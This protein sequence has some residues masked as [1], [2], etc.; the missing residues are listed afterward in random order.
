MKKISKIIFIFASPFAWF[1]LSYF[2]LRFDCPE[3]M[4]CPTGGYCPPVGKVSMMQIMG[5]VPSECQPLFNWPAVIFGLFILLGYTLIILK[6]A[7]KKPQTTGE[8][9][10]DALNRGVRESLERDKAI[11]KP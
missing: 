5:Q 8:M 11:N 6:W 4:T 10:V 7:L 3:Q 2:T 1:G 9:F